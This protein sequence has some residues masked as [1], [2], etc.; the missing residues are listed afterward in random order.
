MISER[1]VMDAVHQRRTGDFSALGLGL[2]LGLG[3]A[4][5]ACTTADVEKVA[6]GEQSATAGN[7][8]EVSEAEAREADEAIQRLSIGHHSRW[9][10][11][12]GATETVRLVAY[13][14]SIFAG[15]RQSLFNLARRAAPNVAAEYF[16]NAWGVNVEVVRRTRSGALA[17]EVYER[18]IVADKS[19]MADPSTRLVYFEMCGNDYLQAR[20]AFRDSSGTCDYRK[21]DAALATCVTYMEKGMQAINAAAVTARQK[22]IAN[23]YY[24]GFDA[25]NV[26]ARCTDPGG[27]GVNIQDK[28]LPY[29]ARSNWNACNLARANGFACVDSFAEFMGADYDSNGDGMIDSDAL[30]WHPDESEADYVNRITVALRSTLRDSNHHGTS[31]DTEGD[32]LLNDDTHP[33]HHLGTFGVGATGKS[34]PDFTDAELATGKNPQWNLY[35]HERMG[36]ALWQA[37]PATL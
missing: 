11:D 14:D 13:G 9:T 17:K 24:P 28:L 32:Y 18:T 6:E 37:G 34:A 15:Y 2:R 30:R 8:S 16:A 31:A 3:L 33:T 10:V 1:K 36:W 23:L 25:D 12:R 27:V 19:W 7:A 20:T 29:M 22:A 21:L 4:I 5:A 26:T 35:G